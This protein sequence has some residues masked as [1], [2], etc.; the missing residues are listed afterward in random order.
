MLRVW[1]G[2]M[3]RWSGYAIFG[4]LV[5]AIAAFGLLQT[6]PGLSWGARVVA[7]LASSPG[8]AV[9][10]KG[11]GGTVPFDMRAE[12]IEIS[13]AKGV[14]LELEDARIDLSATALIRRHVQIDT[15]N[16]GKIEIG[17][18]PEPADPPPPA[19]LADRLR[20]PRLPVSLTIG[21]L[22]VGRLVLDAPL[23][24]ESIEAAIDGHATQHGDDTDVAL[25]LRRTDNKPGG[26]D[27]Q[28]RQSGAD[29]VLSVK[30]TASEPTGLLLNRVL[31]RSDNLPLNISLTGEG[32]LAQW[33]GK[34]DATAGQSARFN[35]D[36]SIEAAHDTTV[37][38][39]GT[40]ALATLLTPQ[41]AAALGDSV[42]VTA[43]VTF[44]E[45]GV[46]ALD[47]LSMRAATGT[48][49]ADAKSGGPDRVVAAHV[50]LT[51]PELA[52][53]S[54]PF[55]PPM[56]GA[57]Q[58]DVTAS[59]TENRPLLRIDGTATGLKTGPSGVDR[60]ESHIA[61]SWP[62]Q[63]NER[64]EIAAQGAIT[65]IT[66]PEALPG[67][68]RDLT[69]SVVGK[70]APTGSTAELTQLSVHGLGVD[71]EA[72]GRM[73]EMG[74][75]L[76][77]QLRL[78]IADLK[79]FTRLLG[80]ASAGQ[81]TLIAVAEQQSPDLVTAT[82]EG[83]VSHLQSGITAADA[84]TG[85]TLTINGSGHRGGDGIV[86]LDTLS[87][88]GAGAVLT[89][90]GRFDPQTRQLSATLDS[91][92]ASL[93]PLTKEMGGRLAGRLTA[94][95]AAEGLLEQ[96]RLQARLEGSNLVAG[97]RT[98]DSIRLD[99]RV[100]DPMVRPQAS[101]TGEFRA[102]GLDGS[103][104]VEALLAA[105]TS[106]RLN[107][108]RVTAGGGSIAGDLQID[109]A[110]LLTS[111]SL[112]ASLPDLAPWSRL[113]GMPLAGRADIRA[114]LT[115]QRGQALELSVNGAGL[116]I[117]GGG[118]TLGQL[119]ANARIADLLGAPL[120]AGQATLSALTFAGGN[121]TKASL[122]LDSAGP[123][124]F[125]F[126]GDAA[127]TVHAPLT[128]AL[129]GTA[130][131][132]PR[133]GAFD[134]Q[135]ARL[136]GMFGADK[137]QLTKALKLSAH[138]SDI[139]MSGLAL[140]YGRGQLSGDVSRRGPAVSL[141]LTGR[142]L[143]LAALGKL[144]GHS[145]I[146]GN[147]A[148]DA[149]VGG[150]LAAPQ[151]HVTVTGSGL[152][153]ALPKQRLPSL[154]LAFDGTWNGRELGFNGRINGLKGAA[155]DVSGSA[156]VVLMQSPFGISL[157]PQGRLVLRLQGAGELANIADLLPLG[158]D[159]L[160]GRFSL[161]A[162]V[163]GTLAAPA[164]SGHLIISDAR[165]ANFA[166]GAVLTRLRADIS[167]DRDRVTVREFS[168]KDSGSGSLDARGSIILSG[169]S[170]SADLAV[171][172]QNFRILGRDEALLAAT[173]SVN[174]A[175]PVASLKIAGQLTTGEG[176]LRIPEDLP[177]SIAKLQVVEIHSREL[178]GRP[179]ASRGAPYPPV[180]R[181]AAKPGAAKAVAAQETAPAL[182]AS[183]DIKIALPGK[184]FVRGR[185]LDSEWRGKFAVTGTSDA[186]RMVGGLEVVRGTFDILGKTF[187]VTRGT[188]TFDGATTLDP[189]LDIVAE[190]AAGD[191][192]ARVLVTGSASA[193][194]IAITSTPT[195]PQEQ[196]LSYV[197]F[198]RPNT[199]ITA[200]E[201]IQVAQ[202]A[203]TLAG[204][205]PG[206]LDRLR[207]RIGLDRLVFGSS[208]GATT[209]SSLNPAAGGGN[210][211]GTSVSGGKYLAEGVYVGATQGLSPQSSKVVVEVEVRPR[212]TVEGDF[213]QKGSTGLGLNYKYDY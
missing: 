182:P 210:T 140:T 117:G 19:P 122:T 169:A 158:E 39:D 161:D 123:G 17:R 28:M 134:L 52:A 160:T 115:P 151:G 211:S 125:S 132:M 27:L 96:P 177:S 80:D 51:V 95:V 178:R 97:T 120:G 124:R 47:S 87:L 65:G 180:R 121:I 77:G 168:A 212:V 203:A 50:R 109:L 70:A 63:P 46:V 102:G 30:I 25:N 66:V 199:Q 196:I 175:G 208:T 10:I 170:P 133:T 200:A 60:L 147:L 2:R 193:P 190:I 44:R 74:R 94:H 139:A 90:S 116:A 86:V 31:A 153:L 13:D 166:T 33:R 150:S 118:I 72:S 73:A 71:A 62:E 126:R 88:K 148:F 89:A 184:I 36:V 6:A 1:L 84:V 152:R 49:T 45:N 174:I 191:V 198:N 154:G 91:V 205:G 5:V 22:S 81:L 167:G 187:K 129:A 179:A 113:A 155:L 189:T 159:S 209:S 106:L 18:I 142:D 110:T 213:S 85:D 29:P 99:A 111:G 34:L 188:I 8:F 176:D 41:M 201:G 105:P 128:V 42:P 21:H 194:M 20:V 163:T 143:D 202:A 24:G 204:G 12:R 206:V 157:P 136:N 162:G 172:L 149:N 83:N 54:G 14:W 16:A 144:A 38:L 197:L 127:G 58:I 75:K 59:G 82:L 101:L 135:L 61:L 112:Y 107:Q 100:T 145:E 32:K 76:N 138:G 164:A 40:A 43:K 98:V 104:S 173:G 64:I 92:I 67:I 131:L 68:S 7:G 186:P 53:V 119:A 23:F 141:H 171:T 37:S 130:E 108:L 137:F 103:L 114:K 78:S 11:L 48:L 69:W 56:E 26:F 156:P 57:V 4:V 93:Q 35:A 181:L 165:Y 195:M 192:V 207:G 9:E 3:L 15:L 146:G 55:G 183:L 185:G 79:P